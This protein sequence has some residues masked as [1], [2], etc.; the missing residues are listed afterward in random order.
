MTSLIIT[1]LGIYKLLLFFVLYYDCSHLVDGSFHSDST[2]SLWSQLD[3]EEQIQFF[4]SVNWLISNINRLASESSPAVAFSYDSFMLLF[5]DRTAFVESIFD[6]ARSFFGTFSRLSSS[7]DVLS[8]SPTHA[9]NSVPATSSGSFT[10]LD[11]K[12]SKEAPSS[13]SSNFSTISELPALVRKVYFEYGKEQ[14][15]SVL[16][17]YAYGAIHNYMNVSKKIS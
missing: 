15:S 10:F 6:P 5:T 11:R 17:T 3:A 1:E 7:V 12:D 2:G 8:P 13:S 16:H 14:P 4:N 9:N